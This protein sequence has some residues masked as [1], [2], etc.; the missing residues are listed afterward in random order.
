MKKNIIIGAV[1]LV[2]GMVS[3]ILC[4]RSYFRGRE[5][6][7]Q[8]DTVVTY[9][10]VHYSRL[11]LK[12]KTYK[13]DV[14]KVGSPALVF[15]PESSTT[16]IYRDSIRYVTLPREYFYTN[17]NDVE[18]WHSGIDSTIDSL[19]VTHKTEVITKSIKP[20]P[21]HHSLGVGVEAICFIN[22]TV[23][24]YGEYAYSP[25]PWFSVYGRVCYDIPARLWGVGLGVR[26][27]VRW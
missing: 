21:K 23:M 13:L 18:I 8:T 2:I 19:N 26:M 25:K 4:S 3:G 6:I 7:V 10:T 20:A 24:P 11:D 1:L 5:P 14:P 15:I 17:V 12:D 9:D 16:I 22:P 27:Q